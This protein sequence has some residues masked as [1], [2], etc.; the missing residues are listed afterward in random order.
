MASDK[1]FYWLFQNQPDRIV[2][3]LTDLPVDAGGYQFSA[4]V[5]KER[6][7]RLDGLFLP[8]ADRPELPAV[9]LE[10]QMAADPGFF[11]RLY[12]ETARLLQQQAVIRNWR[13]VMLCP[14]RQLNFGDPSPVIEFL[15][16]R[17]QWLE[18]LPSRQ[19]ADA[20]LLLQ[21]LGLFV[22][23]EDQVAAAAAALRVKAAGTAVAADLS[24]VITAI[25]VSRFSGRSIPELCAMGGITIE[26]FS[27]SVA[28]QEIFGLGE[29]RGKA[30][31][32]A[33]LALRQLNRRCG[34]ISPGQEATI[35]ALPL[36]K[37]EALAE[38]LLDFSGPAD[39]TAWLK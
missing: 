30:E 10:A 18:L 38:A 36:E 29:A 24:D 32:E 39:L 22:Q 28:Y 21:A 6:E 12:A 14:S 2:P 37:L 7:Y 27:K 33:A 5:L 34:P 15:E 3:L 4:P 35:R 16:Q 31:G 17:V 11:M 23:A 13:V 19:A 25:V 8:P 1:L 9:I 20:P 26:D